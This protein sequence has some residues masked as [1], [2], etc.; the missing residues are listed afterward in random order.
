MVDQPGLE[1]VS[2]PQT[3]FVARPVRQ[4]GAQQIGLVAQA[5]AEKGTVGLGEGQSVDFVAHCRIPVKGVPDV[6]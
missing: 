3:A 5:F 1:L 2:H 4:P 6:P